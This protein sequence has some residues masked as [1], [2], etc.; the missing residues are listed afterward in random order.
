[1]DGSIL[2]ALRN[3]AIGIDINMYFAVRTA[4]KQRRKSSIAQG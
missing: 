2:V 4:K 3:Y 1:M